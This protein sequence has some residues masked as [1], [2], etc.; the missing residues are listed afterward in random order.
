V[1]EIYYLPMN[2][3]GGIELPE[4]PCMLVSLPPRRVQRSRAQEIA[5]VYLTI[6]EGAQPPADFFE[7]SLSA[8]IDT[9]YTSSGS[10]TNGLKAA[11]DHLNALFLEY[12]S[13]LAQ[14]GARPVVAAL[15]MLILKGDALLL[16]HAGPTF[17]AILQPGHMQLYES[18]EEQDRGLGLP[19][20]LPLRYFQTTL[21]ADALLLFT[22]LPS[23][24]WTEN[25]LTHGSRL[26]INLLRRRMLAVEEAAFQACLLQLKP[27]DGWSVHRLRLRSAAAEQTETVAARLLNPAAPTAIEPAPESAPAA[28]EEQPEEPKGTDGYSSQ[29]ITARPPVMTRRSE[30]SARMPAAQPTGAAES[31][32]AARAQT[33]A[34]AARQRMYT[35]QAAAQAPAVHPAKSATVE[36]VRPPREQPEYLQEAQR[37]LATVWRAFSQFQQKI[38]QAAGG[39]VNR[40]AP[41]STQETRGFSKGFLL[42]V[43]ILIPLAVVAAA[44]SIYMQQGRGEQYQMYYDLAAVYAG[45]ARNAEESAA[46]RNNW[47]QAL[48]WLDLAEEYQKTEQSLRL[49]SEANSTLDALDGVVRFS[50][51]ELYPYGF[52]A[53]QNFTQIAVNDTDVYLLDSSD[54]SVKRMTLTGRGYQPDKDFSCSPGIS[55]MLVLD[56]FVDI[57]ALPAG[58]P[59][60]ATVLAV[61]SNGNVAYCIPGAAAPVTV[62]LPVP[63][64][65]WGHIQAISLYQGALYV[66][67]TQKENVYAF[68]GF[69]AGYAQSAYPYFDAERD[70][71]LPDLT[72]MV[73]LAAYGED[74]YLLNRNSTMAYCSSGIWEA[75]QTR[76]D[77]PASFGDMRPIRSEDTLLFENTQFAQVQASSQPEPSLYLLDTLAP[78]VYRFSLQLNL[79]RLFR[80]D[81]ASGVDIPKTAATAFT[82]TPTRNI[83][84][85][86]GNKVFY[87]AQNN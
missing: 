21:P 62:S 56:D 52:D 35:R 57:V 17:S 40:V 73:D 2:V 66:L 13:E 23:E 78:A 4:S 72:D 81:D 47:Q 79:D 61:D 54:G 84:I 16:M 3:E 34:D 76:C 49:R 29:E 71:T 63:E 5:G 12:N 19:G 60:K 46:I 70:V 85:A 18:D 43:A 68:N 6:I 69:L 51:E 45:D 44:V 32:Q 26:T 39:F 53:A 15:N 67:D 14:K 11:A 65:G 75:N 37:K 36:Q 87:S 80:P 59:H 50:F 9:Y 30:T 74:M 77:N 38:S 20:G 41:G 55:G 10:A 27:S 86:F 24:S 82:I 7:K 22:A 1:F 33:R 42:L 48:Y 31:A 83:F 58:S 25:G 28:A 64:D 8:A